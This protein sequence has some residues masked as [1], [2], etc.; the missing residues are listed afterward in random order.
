M[1]RNDALELQI[2]QL[3]LSVNPATALPYAQDLQQVADGTGT[4]RWQ[5]VFDTI[6]SQSSRDGASVGYLPSTIFRLSNDTSSFSTIVATSYSTLSTLIGAGGIPGS[7]T[8]FQL[9]STVTWVQSTARY[10]STADLVSS[11]TPFFT[12]NLSFMSNIQS[13]VIGLG[14]ANYIS[15]PQLISTTNGL[16]GQTRSTVIGLGSANYISSPQLTSTVRGLGQAGYLSTNALFSTVTGMLYPAS[17]VGGSLGVVITGSADPPF[18]NFNAL[19]AAY[20]AANDYFNSTNANSYGVVFGGALPST[21]V[22]LISSLGSR[23]YVSTATLLSTSAG[24]QAAKQ[25]IFID[26]MGNTAIFNSDVYISSVA[27]ITFLSSFVNSSITYQG[28]NGN[29][30]AQVAANSNLTFST[31]NLQFDRFSSFITSNSRITVELYPTYQFDSLTAGSLTSKAFAMSTTIQNGT[32]NLGFT[33]TTLVPATASANGYSN[34]FQQPIKLTFPATA[35]GS[36]A[37]P[38]VITH[39]VVGGLSY[40]TQVGFRDSNL[41]VFFP[42]TNSYFLSVQNLTF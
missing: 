23:G 5:T 35:L 7:I 31:A 20:L 19:N 12:G 4:R 36:Y 18:Q 16:Q 17:N 34:F 27:A 9:Q 29:M 22:G 15:S 10:I 40:L 26:R 21:T 25:N 41:N 8:T 42:S 38:H 37:A 33:Y 6:S 2:Q 28:T 32:S 30:A 1:S 24:I 39:T 13:T 3:I 11:M 14:S